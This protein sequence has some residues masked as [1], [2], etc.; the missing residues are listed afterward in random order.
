MAIS[1]KAQRSYKAIVGVPA[2]GMVGA[3]VLAGC[4][5]DSNETSSAAKTTVTQTQTETVKKAPQED[6][7]QPK[8]ADETAMTDSVEL[9]QALEDASTRNSQGEVLSADGENVTVCANGDGGG[10]RLAAAAEGTDCDFAT[11]VAQEQMS[12]AAVG[13]GAGATPLRE[14]FLKDLTVTDP[15][16]GENTDVTCSL[17]NDVIVCTADGNRTAYLY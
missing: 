5:T 1:L 3:L 16:S 15:Q 12:Q 9:R 11:M 10:I 4:S 8:P 2:L 17:D 14:I 13:S 6:N 7:T